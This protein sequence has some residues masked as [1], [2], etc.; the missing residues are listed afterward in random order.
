MVVT[1]QL[2]NGTSWGVPRFYFH[3]ILFG[4]VCVLWMFHLAIDV[5]RV[6][7]IAWIGVAALAVSGVVGA[8]YL[9]K[10]ERTVVEGEYVLLA[11]LVGREYEDVEGFAATNGNIDG[12]DDMVE[13]IDERLAAGDRVAMDTIN[14]MPFLLSRHPRQFIIPESRDSERILADPIGRFELVLI[15]PGRR[16]GYGVTLDNLVAED[17]RWVLVEDLEPFGKLYEFQDSE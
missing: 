6:L 3:L 14:G 4:A 15:Q 8:L 2:V 9:A 1:V 17:P 12:Y 13:R 10:P 11:P 7:P 5:R 16:T